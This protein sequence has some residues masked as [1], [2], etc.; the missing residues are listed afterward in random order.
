[1]TDADVISLALCLHE[2]VDTGLFLHA[3]DAVLKRHR[4]LCIH[5]VHTNVA[6]AITMFDQVNLD[7]LWLA[8]GTK[9]H[10][11]YIPIHE[12]VNKMDAII[13]K[14]LPVSM[15]SLYVTLFQH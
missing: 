4:K 1:M 3:E 10:F 14:T 2:E 15:H 5:T 6:L 8:F 13:I 11:H 9:V 12:I 7:E